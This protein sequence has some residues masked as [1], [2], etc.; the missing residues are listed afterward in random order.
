[1]WN[2]E[3]HRLTRQE[4]YGLVWAEPAYKVADRF[5]ISGVAFAKRCRNAGI[6]L[7]ERR[8]WARLQFGKDAKRAPLKQRLRLSLR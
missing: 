3:R 5:A 2:R 4:L 1:M 7:P 6:P 8:Y